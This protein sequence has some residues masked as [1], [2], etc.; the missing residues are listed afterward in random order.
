MTPALLNAF[1]MIGLWIWPY[2]LSDPEIGVNDISSSGNGDKWLTWRWSTTFLI[3]CLILYDEPGSLLIIIH[4]PVYL[5]MILSTRPFD[6]S[7]WMARWQKTVSPTWYCRGLG[8]SELMNSLWYALCSL[9]NT[10]ATLLDAASNWACL[11]ANDK[12][13]LMED[14]SSLSVSLLRNQLEIEIPAQ[15]QQ[16]YMKYLFLGLVLNS[17]HIET[18][19]CL[20]LPL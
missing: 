12:T 19:E 20:L 8:C 2:S 18:G 13:D 16:D 15:Q 1:L 3:L 4:G 17:R 11:L 10:L 6:L 14:D 5:N 7:L 9:I